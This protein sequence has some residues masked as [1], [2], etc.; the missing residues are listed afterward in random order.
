MLCGQQQLLI[1]CVSTGLR[2]EV[3]YAKIKTRVLR[4]LK[5]QMEICK[6]DIARRHFLRLCTSLP[7]R[8]LIDHSLDGLNSLI[9]FHVKVYCFYCKLFSTQKSAFC[10]DG[11]YDWKNGSA[12]ICA[13]EKSTAHIAAVQSTRNLSVAAARID[14][15][16]QCGMQIL[17]IG[18]RTCI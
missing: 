17:Q 2:R 14:E 5:L 10:G 16:I 15:N 6:H 8:N 13:H 12:T 18:A 4:H 11:F 1:A 7:Q 3:N 9:A